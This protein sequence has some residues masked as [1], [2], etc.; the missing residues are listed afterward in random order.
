MVKRNR[1]MVIFSVLPP[2][3]VPRSNDI[4]ENFP[5]LDDY[6]N[7]VP[8]NTDFP[9][10]LSDQSFNMWYNDKSQLE[11]IIPNVATKDLKYCT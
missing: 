7:T 6:T 11:F 4:P 10:G 2:V 1:T 3:L 8:E 5:P 9:S